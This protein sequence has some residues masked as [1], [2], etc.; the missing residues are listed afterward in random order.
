[1]KTTQILVKA[2]QVNVSQKAGL[3]VE[4]DMGAVKRFRL[5]EK[6]TMQ[7][8]I[9]QSCDTM[10]ATPAATKQGQMIFAKN[11]DRPWDEC[12]P[13]ELH[14]RQEHAPDS[15]TGTQ[16][17]AVP[18]VKTTWRHVG[19]RPWWC[20]GYEHGFNEH[21]VVIGN[22]ALPSRL[23]PA[24][25]P[26]LIGM[27]ILRLG[28]ERGQTA[29]QAVAVMTGLIAEYGQGKFDNQAGVRTYDNSY[30]V[31]DPTEA[32]VIETAGHQWAVKRVEGALGISN[33]YSIET[34]Y[35][36][37]A[38]KAA[39]LAAQKGWSNADRPF[40]FADAFAAGPRS[41][42]SGAR[43]RKRS[44]ALL[45]NS[46]G[47]IG[48]ETMLAV[49]RDHSDASTP[50][51]PFQAD[52]NPG[53]GICV[54][55]KQEADGS[56]SGGNTAASLIADLCADGSRLPVYWCSFYS[57]CLSLFYPV[58]LEADLPPILAQ[59]GQR[60]KDD[61][62]SPWW[63]FHQLNTIAR[64]GGPAAVSAVRQRWGQLQNQWMDS[65]YKIA[66]AG[67]RLIDADQSEV[68]AAQLTVYVDENVKRMLKVLDELSETAESRVGAAGT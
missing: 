34:D 67:K 60:Q 40:N 23:E 8:T 45:G 25:E 17:V 62:D 54:H 11:S 20:W 5:P 12:Q 13:L 63:R 2:G 58:F 15:Q 59:G 51:E 55:F 24:N 19:S 30:I 48:V 10:V 57:P 53:Q 39:A 68:A 16:F 47:S 26:K 32:F 49:L 29:R 43:R 22:E 31:A 1:M 37:L 64:Q 42:G 44:C 3:G 4:I 33:V 46:S 50:D 52:I 21:Q 6:R 7:Q 14:Q 61:P 35:E 56:Q 65:A 66:A 28:L 38:P 18:Q 36:S 27:E 41:E 9:P